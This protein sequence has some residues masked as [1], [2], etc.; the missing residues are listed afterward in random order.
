MVQP[1][2]CATMSLNAASASLY[3]KECSN[4]TP[5]LNF[6]CIALLHEVLKLTLPSTWLDDFASPSCANA[7]AANSVAA[8]NAVVLYIG[9]L[10]EE[11][12]T[13]VAPLA[14]ATEGD[15]Y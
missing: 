8:M 9:N 13:M 3:Q 11:R 6:G 14:A 15:R 12:I 5:R 1:G 10:Q 7:W 2:S 4:A